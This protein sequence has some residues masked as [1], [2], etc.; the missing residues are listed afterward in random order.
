VM[1]VVQYDIKIYGIKNCDT[2]KKA[3]NFLAEQQ[4]A[5]H[6]HDYR[7]DGV[8]DT[9]LQHAID[10]LGWE[11]LINQRGTTWRGLTDADKQISDAGAA[12]ALMQRHPAVIKRPLLQRGDQF[13]VGFDASQYQQFCL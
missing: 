11:K 6:F 10:S 2:M 4:I 13:L 5:V 9:V 3:R 1:S 8:P 12:L 7:T